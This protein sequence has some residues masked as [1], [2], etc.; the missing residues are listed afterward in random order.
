ME[1]FY[2]VD[3]VKK[4]V[5]RLQRLDLGL[6]VTKKEYNEVNTDLI[7][8]FGI[9]GLVILNT[10]GFRD[11][12]LSGSEIDFDQL[13]DSTDLLVK[14]RVIYKLG[15]KTYDQLT[16]GLLRIGCNVRT[17]SGP[18]WVKKYTKDISSFDIWIGSEYIRSLPDMPKTIIFGNFCYSGQTNP[19][20]DYPDPIGAAFMNKKLLSYYCYNDGKGNSNTVK[21]IFAK[22]MEDSLTKALLVDIDSTGN[23][24]LSYKGAEF[25]DPVYP[26]YLKQYGAMDY[27]YDNCVDVFTDNRDGI[28]YKAVCIGKQNWMA[29]NLRYNA[30]ASVFYDNDPSN[31]SIYGR[32]YSWNTA[33][34]GGATNNTNPSGVQGI[35]PKGWHLPSQA[36]WL[37]L[38]E[39]LGGADQAGKVLKS[40]KLW[41]E[42]GNGT[43]ASGF[44]ALP[45]GIYNG[46]HWNGLKEAAYFWSTTESSSDKS[47]VQILYLG[48]INQKAALTTVIKTANGATDLLAP[49]RCL[50][51]K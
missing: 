37:Q 21:N 12:F 45:S 31:G 24:H 47:R 44:T 22:A 1:E 8:T 34:K 25:M 48:Y 29:E 20:K 17:S 28:I 3:E 19:T 14:E 32:L 43:N 39:F 9:Y 7:S 38:T 18:D 42:N 2:K 13:F 46:I 33:M 51:D 4:L 10:H 23:S 26:I 30:P 5:T 40:D 35:C 16:S 15:Q 49:C 27:S 36:E 6:D 50:K 41:Y 11:C